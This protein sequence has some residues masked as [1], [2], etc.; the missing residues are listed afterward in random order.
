MLTVV[1][2]FGN[3][4][5]TIQIGTQM[6]HFSTDL[7]IRTPV[8]SLMELHAVFL[9]LYWSFSPQDGKLFILF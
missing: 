7:V 2:P 4:I 3:V 9:V 6:S 8:A 5:K 1:P